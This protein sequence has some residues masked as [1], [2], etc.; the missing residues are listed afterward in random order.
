MPVRVHLNLSLQQVINREEISVQGNS[1]ITC[2]ED[3][4]KQ[5]PQ[6]KER[7][8]NRD[9]SLALLVLLNNG[10]LPEQNLN[11]PV[12][13]NDELWLMSIVSGG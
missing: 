11:H 5:Y 1:I 9:G 13:D 3:L 10:V 7:I 4:M 8:F 6:A 2:L 12:N